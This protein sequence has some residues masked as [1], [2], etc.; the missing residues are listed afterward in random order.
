[1]L[2]GALALTAYGLVA[3]LQPN[4]EFGRVLAAYGS[5]FIVRLAAVGASPSTAPPRPLR[6]AGAL[7]CMAGVASSCSPAEG[8][9]A[10]QGAF[11]PSPTASTH[12][13][14]TNGPH[15][16]FVPQMFRRVRPQR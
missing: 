15:G 10:Q 12:A 11:D 4:N 13:H 9:P 16:R 14:A 5:V 6:L 3:A 2:A 7:I 8:S 1:M